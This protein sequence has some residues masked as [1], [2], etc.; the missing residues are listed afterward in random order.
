MSFPIGRLP[1][2][3]PLRPSQPG[4]IEP[5]AA[6]EQLLPGLRLLAQAMNLD[7]ALGG[8]LIVVAALVVGREL[9]AVQ[10]LVALAAD[11]RRLAFEQLH[12][13]QAAD[14]ALVAR[15]EGEQ[16]LVKATEP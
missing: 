11:H 13:R 7:E 4:Q 2:P 9:L 16:I 5:L 14:E 8:G 10:S 1:S 6:L 15:H 12:S 3:R